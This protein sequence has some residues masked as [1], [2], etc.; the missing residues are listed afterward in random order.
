MSDSRVGI[1]YDTETIRYSYAMYENLESNEYSV[2]ITFNFK[3]PLEIQK[4]IAGQMKTIIGIDA[5]T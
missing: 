5:D 2:H 1:L 3:L 4:Q